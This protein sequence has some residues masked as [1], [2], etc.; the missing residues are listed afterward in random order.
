MRLKM[1]KT[2]IYNLK[3][4]KLRA[5]RLKINNQLLSISLAATATIVG[6]TPVLLLPVYAQTTPVPVETTSE[7]ACTEGFT[8]ET[9]S[10]VVRICY[11]R[12]V[13][14]Y[15]GT[16]KDGSGYV[17]LNATSSNQVYV[18]RNG[19]FTY[20]LNMNDKLL[21]ITTPNGESYFEPVIRV[22]DS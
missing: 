22:V 1:Y 14:L 10:Y 9:N 6:F 12:G 2:K 21:I 20:T 16:A 4:N 15:V 8:A 17:N 5:N 7:V 19:G 18:A 13:L 3:V 11:S